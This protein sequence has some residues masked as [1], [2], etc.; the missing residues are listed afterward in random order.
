MSNVFSTENRPAYL[1]MPSTGAD[2]AWRLRDL[3]EFQGEVSV[4]SGAAKGD[5][6]IATA[7]VRTLPGLLPAWS[8]PI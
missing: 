4:F 6:C 5:V 1:A 7:D 8:P 2:A 3:A